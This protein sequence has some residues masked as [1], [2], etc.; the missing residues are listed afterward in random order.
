MDWAICG[1]AIEWKL[2][3]KIVRQPSVETTRKRQSTERVALSIHTSWLAIRV[4]EIVEPGPILCPH[5]L[6]SIGSSGVVR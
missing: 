4:A 6:Q 2:D 5:S 3:T 1:A